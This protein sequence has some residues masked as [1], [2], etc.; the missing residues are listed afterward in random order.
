MIMCCLTLALHLF[1]V[2]LRFFLGPVLFRFRLFAFI[3][4]AGLRSIVL[5]YACIL[6]A[7]RSYLTTVFF[8]LFLSFLGGIDF[9]ELFD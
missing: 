5:Q 4:A 2:S 8:V 9:S 1:F 6:T 3:E 7:T